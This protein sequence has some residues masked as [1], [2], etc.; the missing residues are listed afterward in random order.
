MRVEGLE[1]RSR[2][3]IQERIDLVIRLRK[4]MREYREMLVLEHKVRAIERP[5]HRTLEAVRNCFNNVT[6]SL[7]PGVPALDG[8]NADIFNDANDLLSLRVATEDDRLTRFLQTTFPILFAK[9]APGSDL[10]SHKQGCNPSPDDPLSYYSERRL[11]AC[12]AIIYIILA[13]GLLFG[14]MFNLYFVGS[15]PK[16]LGLI[17][18]YT[19]VFALCVGFLSNARRAEIF[20]AC[21]AYAAVLVVFVSGGLSCGAASG[22]G[23]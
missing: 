4:T 10:E 6:S 3:Q 18:G 8:R 14:A 1:E 7:R 15:N 22:S 5:S 21:A 23:G 13:S 19:V 12:V 11:H 9:Q 2:L 16:R 20:G 17:A